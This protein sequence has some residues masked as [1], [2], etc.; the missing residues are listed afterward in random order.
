MPVVSKGWTSSNAFFKAEG[1]Q[2]NIGLG[3]G[4]AL[5]TFNSNIQGFSPVRQ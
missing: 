4:K 2:I 5:N 3:Q 1:A